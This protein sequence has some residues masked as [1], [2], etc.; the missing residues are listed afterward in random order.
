MP[1]TA[2]RV[3]VRNLI[4]VCYATGMR[5]HA[6]AHLLNTS[7]EVV[8]QRSGIGVSPAGDAH[9]TGVR[10]GAEPNGPRAGIEL[11][12]DRLAEL[13]GDHHHGPGRISQPTIDEFLSALTRTV[14]ETRHGPRGFADSLERGIVVVADH[15]R[16]SQQLSIFPGSRCV[17][18]HGS[19]EK[20]M[21]A[22]ADKYLLRDDRSTGMP[23]MRHVF[24][25]GY[26]LLP[27]RVL[28]SS[29]HGMLRGISD[30]TEGNLLV[31]SVVPVDV[32]RLFDM[33][34]SEDHY[35]SM[36]ASLGLTPVWEEAAA[37]IRAYVALQ[38][39]RRCNP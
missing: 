29:I 37:F 22:W 14:I 20:A 6:V 24:G 26:D 27:R 35:R 17:V 1:L 2:P 4:C 36:C 30:M 5:G 3:N 31:G 19:T 10:Y 9:Q 12:P 15:I 21:R 39:Q 11:Y 18:L 38:N 23:N 34:T 28:K 25:E 7:P 8:D 16:A 13:M 32:D 33:E